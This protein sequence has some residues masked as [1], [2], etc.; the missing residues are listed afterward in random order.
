MEESYPS[1]CDNFETLYEKYTLYQKKLT[2][3]QQSL[4][5]FALNNDL[6]DDQLEKIS[7]FTDDIFNVI[8]TRRYKDYLSNYKI[9][10]CDHINIKDINVEKRESY[11]D[12]RFR[13]DLFDVYVTIKITGNWIV[14][15]IIYIKLEDE[16][17]DILDIDSEIS[18]SLSKLENNGYLSKFNKLCRIDYR[19][20]DEFKDCMKY[21][22]D[23]D[24]IVNICYK[25]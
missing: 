4:I 12:V 11:V 23:K 18:E 21:I 15:N 8:I 1:D 25:V 10:I 17:I 13:S 3:C 9:K 5:Q 20:G 2:Q 16:G 24:K 19:C 22:F 7:D 6:S 14:G